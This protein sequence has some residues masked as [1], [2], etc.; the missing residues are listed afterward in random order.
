M[1]RT[2]LRRAAAALLLLAVPLVTGCAEDPY[3]ILESAIQ[4]ESLVWGP[5]DVIEGENP[6][7]RG[8]MLVLRGRYYPDAGM[9]YAPV[10]IPRVHITRGF[11]EALLARKAR[12]G[13][14]FDLLA[15]GSV[16]EGYDGLLV[17]RVSMEEMG[18]NARALLEAENSDRTRMV[19]EIRAF[20][21]LPEES[22]R[23]LA[24]AFAVARRYGAPEGIAMERR[25]GEWTVTSRARFF[26]FAGRGR[27]AWAYRPGGTTDRYSE[28]PSVPPYA[29]DSPRTTTSAQPGVR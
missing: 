12:A 8:V 18:E 26:P 10:E 5:F 21:S 27:D 25:P 24:H 1:M 15:A 2:R 14:V 7:G 29:S 4:V 9:V 16:G 13:Q 28:A 19:E 3:G 20:N 23:D 11:G 22:L 17:P 6:Q